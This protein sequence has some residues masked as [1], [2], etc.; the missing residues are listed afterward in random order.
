MWCPAGLADGLSNYQERESEQWIGEW[1]KE[2][3]C[4]DEMVYVLASQRS[5]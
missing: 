5:V 3:N 2:R 1:M 4:R